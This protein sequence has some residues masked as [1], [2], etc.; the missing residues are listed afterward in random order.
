MDILKLALTIVFGLICNN[1]FASITV[2]DFT[3]QELH[4]KQ[5]ASRI[6][7]L[8]PNI[9]ETLFA[10]GAGKSVVAVSSSSNYPTA[11]TKLP[12][13]ASNSQLDLEKIIKL[14]PDLVIA[15]MQGNPTKALEKLQS[16]GVRIFFVKITELQDVAKLYIKLGKVTGRVRIA[17][18][19]A[20][21]YNN[22]LLKLKKNYQHKKNLQV[23][24]EIWQQPIFT[25]GKT[26][27]ISKAI[28]LCGGS[29]SFNVI[30]QQAAEVSL[31]AV[32]KKNPDVIISGYGKVHWKSYWLK[33]RELKAVQN[34]QLYYINPDLLQRNGPRLLDGINKLCRYINSAR[35]A[36]N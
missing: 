8:A 26:S 23:F 29:N 3:G 4:F 9:T 7:S 30:A 10:L 6:I 19:L 16:L 13:V 28:H 1:A 34:Q 5:A 35:Q 32:L 27:L 36:R 15:W 17:K 18:K 20:M 12:V 31:A 14:K 21:D 25:I 24:Y 33:W 2:T 11:A 22:S